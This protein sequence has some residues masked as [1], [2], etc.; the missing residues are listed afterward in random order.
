MNKLPC[1]A[2]GKEL[3]FQKSPGFLAGGM[4]Q[5]PRLLIFETCADGIFHR[6]PPNL[7]LI[8]ASG[9]GLGF[10]LAGV[11]FRLLPASCAGRLADRFAIR[12]DTSE[13]FGAAAPPPLS[14]VSVAAVGGV[15][16][17]DVQHRN[18]PPIRRLTLVAV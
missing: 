11:S 9:V 18:R 4:L 5:T 8:D 3:A 12:Q 16:G 13:P 14:V 6:G 15:A 1:L 2:E 10:L 17:I 7:D